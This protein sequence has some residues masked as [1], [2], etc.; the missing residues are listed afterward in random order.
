MQYFVK[1]A[2]IRE[3]NIPSATDAEIASAANQLG[4][5]VGGSSARK[6]RTGQVLQR[7]PHGGSHMVAVEIKRSRQI[8]SVKR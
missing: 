6:S 8:Y 1:A 5:N 2:E 4:L 3:P 7:L